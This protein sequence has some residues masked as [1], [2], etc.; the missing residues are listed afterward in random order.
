MRHPRPALAR[1]RAAGEARAAG[2]AGA[3][4]DLAEEADLAEV[5]VEIGGVDDKV[6][7]LAIG[8]S[9]DGRRRLGRRRER[10]P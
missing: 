4:R 5:L 3:L 7:D 9:G 2:D 6:R 1:A 10:A 8:G